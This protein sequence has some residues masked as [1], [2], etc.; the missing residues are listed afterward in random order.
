MK[1]YGAYLMILKK[2]SGNN[3]FK[4][5]RLL[6]FILLLINLWNSMFS[7]DEERIQRM[8][9]EKG[10]GEIINKIYHA[11]D[12]C[13][14]V[15][16]PYDKTSHA[17]YG[18][19]FVFGDKIRWEDVNFRGENY[20]YKYIEL[21]ENTSAF[22][23]DATFDDR[24]DII[25]LK[26]FSGFPG[27]EIIKLDYDLKNE[28]LSFL[29]PDSFYCLGANP[30]I[31]GPDYLVFNDFK[32]CIVNGKR[33]VRAYS[34]GKIRPDE[35]NHYYALMN[36]DKDSHYFFF[37]WDKNEQRYI[38]DE[39][40]TD[41]QLKNAWCP[42]D[43]F[44][45]N[46]LKFSKLDSKLID[47]DLK[48][49]DKAQLRLMRNAVY[50]RHGRTFKSVDLQSLWECYTWYKKNPNYNDSMLTDID[51]YNIELIQKYEAK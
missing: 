8:I 18:I 12:D 15:T 42:E 34:I 4:R 49:L 7:L 31:T 1:M 44:A 3:G 25:W 48:D 24:T 27:F 38:L 30:R 28:Y 36:E 2:I 13:Y 29:S 11:G 45:Y 46:G 26:D 51:K 22:L 19:Y 43:Y 41:N 35:Y 16:Y 9:N 50:A 6:I 17:L 23:A 5:K 39:T 40:V 14:I 20:N 21:I 32:F 10:S 47:A 37:Y 33:G